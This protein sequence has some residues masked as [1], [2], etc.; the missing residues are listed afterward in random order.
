MTAAS[1][2][3]MDATIPRRFCVCIN[4]SSYLK[5]FSPLE[6][7]NLKSQFYILLAA[8]MKTLF[9]YEKK[10]M[11]TKQYAMDGVIHSSFLHCW[12]LSYRSIGA[13][14]T[15][16]GYLISIDNHFR[17]INTIIYRCNIMNMTPAILMDV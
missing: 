5:L 17:S 12:H 1:R 13:Q 2:A 11:R 10:F 16:E 4:F 15:T 14:I 3:G 8:L 7:L 6:H 9:W